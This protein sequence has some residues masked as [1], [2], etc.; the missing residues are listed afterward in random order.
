MHTFHS[1]QALQ[2]VIGQEVAV[3]PWWQITQEQVDRFAH[4]TGVEGSLYAIL[5]S[6]F[7]LGQAIA[8]ILGGIVYELIGLRALI[9]LTA[10]LGLSAFLVLAIRSEYSF[11]LGKLGGVT[12]PVA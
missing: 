1:L 9:I 3:S 11:N 12:A 8:G 6:L 2:S 4:A 5:M 7:N 10:V